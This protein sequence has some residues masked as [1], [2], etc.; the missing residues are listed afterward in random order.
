MAGVS[1]Y[2]GVYICNE[3]KNIFLTLASPRTNEVTS[4]FS[5]HS[6]NPGDY[7]FLYYLFFF[8]AGMK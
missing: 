6:V 4:R 8:Y 1:S 7:Y 5:I 3:E 2:Q